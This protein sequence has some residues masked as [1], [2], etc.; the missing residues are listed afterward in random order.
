MVGPNR[1][2]RV[3]DAREDW[4]N[5][6]MKNPPNLWT[7]ANDRDK[8]YPN[9]P[10]GGYQPG[11]EP[12]IMP[13][14]LSGRFMGFGVFP[15]ETLGGVPQL[16]HDRASL[17]Q[18]IL[19]PGSDVATPTGG[20]VLNPSFNLPMY[21][22]DVMRDFHV[23]TGKLSWNANEPAPKAIDIQII[24]DEMARLAAF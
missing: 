3:D 10:T 12:R 24:N 22:G 16:R 9:P 15:G 2:F 17:P 13:D 1:G 6:A 21:M 23:T 5:K 20:R 18:I 4:E 19:N 7:V 14:A 11:D 8:F